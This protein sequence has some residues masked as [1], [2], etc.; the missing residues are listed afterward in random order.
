MM[1]PAWL[2]ITSL[3]VTLPKYGND[4]DRALTPLLMTSLVFHE[5]HD[6]SESTPTVILFQQLLL[7]PLPLNV[8]YA[9]Y[10]QH[11]DLPPRRRSAT[12]SIHREPTVPLRLYSL[13]RPFNDAQCTVFPIP[14]IFPNAL[15]KGL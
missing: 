9:G 13:L 15:G 5:Q 7:W 11:P 3:R 14:S 1:R 2:L 10:W 12:P 4:D 8:V 6:S